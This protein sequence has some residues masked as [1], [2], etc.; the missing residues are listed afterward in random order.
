MTPQETAATE[1]RSGRSVNSPADARRWQNVAVYA[2]LALA[3][4]GQID[5]GAQ[6]APDQPLDLLG[7]AALPAA[8]RLAVGPG[9]GRA[10]QHAVFG[11]HPAL[12]AVAQKRRHPLLDRGGA[13]HLGVAELRQARAFGIFRHT[14]FEGDRAHRIGSAP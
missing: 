14:R 6:A 1:S 11:R 10:R 7:A 8:G 12:A 4:K 3:E 2:D 9:R 13:E 5:D